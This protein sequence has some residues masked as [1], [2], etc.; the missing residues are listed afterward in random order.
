M[1]L[2]L[3][4]LFWQSLWAAMTLRIWC[5]SF[6]LQTRYLNSFCQSTR[7]GKKKPTKVCICFFFLSVVSIFGA[8]LCGGVFALRLPEILFR[9]LSLRCCFCCSLFSVGGGLYFVSLNIHKCVW[10]LDCL[11][12]F[13]INKHQTTKKKNA[14]IPISQRILLPLKET[15][16]WLYHN[17]STCEAY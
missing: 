12:L 1:V 7:V 16:Q 15:N 13:T 2:I 8:K 10:C 17:N 6:S 14:S 11:C 3:T 5:L 4:L 9:V